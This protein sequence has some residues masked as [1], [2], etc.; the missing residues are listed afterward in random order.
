MG[1]GRHRIRAGWAWLLAV[2]AL[3]LFV[4]TL[5]SPA[6]GAYPKVAVALDSQFLTN[7][8]A[9]VLA[10]GQSG[11]IDYRLANPLNRALTNATLSFEVYAFNAYPGQ[12]MGFPDNS[13]GLPAGTATPVLSLGGQQGASLRVSVAVLAPG[14]SVSFPLGVSAGGALADGTY[15]VRTSLSFVSAGAGYLLESRGFISATQWANATA[16]GNGT[17]NVSR[18][19]VSGVLPETAVLVRMQDLAFPLYVVLGAAFVLAV[20]GAY[21]AWRGGPGSKSGARGT[22]VDHSAPSAFGKSRTSDGD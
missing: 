2:G 4:G 13:T 9:P 12:A 17:L 3:L 20:A 7:L 14:A 22:P 15:A 8:S 16:G 18:L 19:P 6:S 21:F 5:P 10:P 11:S 1:N